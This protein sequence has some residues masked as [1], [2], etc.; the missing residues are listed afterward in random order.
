MQPNNISSNKNAQNDIEMLRKAAFC[1]I[2]EL[3]EEEKV[4]V[5]SK[6]A[7]RCGIDL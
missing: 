3:T 2:M 1:A 4:R 6:Y 5:L 7:E